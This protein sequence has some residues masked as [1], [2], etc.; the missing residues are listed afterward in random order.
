MMMQFEM[1]DK[2]LYAFLPSFEKLDCFANKNKL[3]KAA[4][5][6]TNIFL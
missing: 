1:N 6:L 2:V 3:N 5:D 4:F